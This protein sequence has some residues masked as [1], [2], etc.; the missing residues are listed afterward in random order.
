MQ[1]LHILKI[2][3]CHSAFA[4]IASQGLPEVVRSHEQWVFQPLIDIAKKKGSELGL[5][6]VEVD[7]PDG[8]EGGD[9]KEKEKELGFALLRTSPWARRGCL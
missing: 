9:G 2:Q 3:L 6:E 4:E 8:G 1:G 5:F 7:W